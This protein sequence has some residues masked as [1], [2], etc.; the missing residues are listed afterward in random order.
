MHG[1]GQ[2]HVCGLLLLLKC[3][4]HGVDKQYIRCCPV[5]PVCFLHPPFV[6]DDVPQPQVCGVKRKQEGTGSLQTERAAAAQMC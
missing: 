4:V 3:W 1:Q 2:G 5:V 6:L